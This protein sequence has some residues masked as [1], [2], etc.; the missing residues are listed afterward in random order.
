MKRRVGS[1]F[2]VACCGALL[3]G[4]CA[5][6]GAE[7]K[8]D[9][10]VVPVAQ[11]QVA[12]KSE[13]PVQAPVQKQAQQSAA[14]QSAP[15]QSPALQQAAAPESKQQAEA[16]ETARE[17]ASL[18]Q[19]LATIY[20]GFD[21]PKLTEAARRTLAQDADAIKKFAKGTVRVEG[22]CDERGSDDYN[23]ALGEKRAQEAVQYLVNLGVPRERLSA[24]SYGKEKPVAAGHD[25]ASWAKNRRDDFVVIP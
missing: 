16:Q 23:L 6:Q 4:G 14:E 10:G 7:V 18:Q 13:A 8:K 21:S 20:F 5:K 24:I 11:A 22:N 12:P 3:A 1:L 2:L 17:E 19:G 15:A 9:E 25:E